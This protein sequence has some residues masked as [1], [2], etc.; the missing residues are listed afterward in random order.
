MFFGA[1]A[2]ESDADGLPARHC[3]RGRSSQTSTKGTMTAAPNFAYALLAKRLRR[4]AKARRLR[5]VHLRFALSVPNP[6]TYGRRGP[7]G[8]RQAVRSQVIGHPPGLRAWPGDDIGGLVLGVQRRTGR[9]RGSMPTCWPQSAVRSRVEGQHPSACD[10]RTA[11]DGPKALIV[12]KAATSCRPVC[13]I[14]GNWRGE[15]LFD[16]RFT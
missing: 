6:S 15:S 14:I 2:G 9:R 5:S 7:A 8:R 13:G 11:A 16:S 12:V 1:E 10:A 4:Q 3:C